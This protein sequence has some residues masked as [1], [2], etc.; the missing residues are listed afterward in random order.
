M[1]SS[2]QYFRSDGE[3]FRVNEQ[4]RYEH[5]VNGKWEPYYLENMFTLTATPLSPEEA[6]AMMQRSPSAK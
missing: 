5:Y 3:L 6:R 2:W 1:E 4:F